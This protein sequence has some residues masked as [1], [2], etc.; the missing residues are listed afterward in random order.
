V[1]AGDGG[2]AQGLE[3]CQ[4]QS[5]DAVRL[6]NIKHNARLYFT[7]TFHAKGCEIFKAVI[8]RLAPW[9][10]VMND[11]FLIS[12]TARALP[13]VAFK[14][15][16]SAFAPCFSP[17]AGLGVDRVFGLFCGKT[18]AL[19]LARAVVS[20]GKAMFGEFKIITAPFTG[21]EESFASVASAFV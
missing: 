21:L 11:E 19:T 3:E 13:A 20:A 1:G 2:A 7:V 14:G 15:F 17:T 9:A 4:L 12:T 6:A 8:L 5:R 10:D 16:E 18:L